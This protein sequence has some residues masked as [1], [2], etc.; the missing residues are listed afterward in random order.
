VQTG[1][2]PHQ[3]HAHYHKDEV[4]VSATKA[5]IARFFVVVTL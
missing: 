4:I 2:V 5:M 1:L 3:H